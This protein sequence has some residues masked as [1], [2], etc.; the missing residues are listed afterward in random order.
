MIYIII[1][2]SYELDDCW[3]GGSTIDYVSSSKEKAQDFFEKKRYHY[4]NLEG[5]EIDVDE[6]THFVVFLDNWCY[7]YELNEYPEDVDLNAWFIKENNIF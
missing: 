3:H 7:D 4:M 5:N 2:D 1:D 6:P